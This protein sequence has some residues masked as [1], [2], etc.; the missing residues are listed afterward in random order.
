MN[1]NQEIH[2]LREALNIINSYEYI[3]QY[4]DK[5]NTIKNEYMKRYE[6]QNLDIIWP[7]LKDKCIC[8]EKI[9]IQCYIRKKNNEDSS[10]INNN[11]ESKPGLLENKLVLISSLLNNNPKSKSG[12]LENKLVLS[13]DNKTKLLKESNKV[14]ILNPNSCLELFSSKSKDN[15]PELKESLLVVCKN[16]INKFNIKKK[17]IKCYGN[18]KR[19]KSNICK[20]CDRKT[21]EYEKNKKMLEKTIIPF[22]KYKNHTIKDICDKDISYIKWCYKIHL[23]NEENSCNT[24]CKENC[25]E[26]LNPYDK[27]GDIAYYYT[28]YIN[29]SI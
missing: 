17:C 14:D 8:G 15:N 29:K 25:I 16:C 28:N 13:E 10:L 19:S 3:G 11:P 27:F 12:L 7:E 22:G 6:L 18:H 20:E 9:K 2:K 26:H 5:N 4:L 23:E 1:N 24:N 21:K